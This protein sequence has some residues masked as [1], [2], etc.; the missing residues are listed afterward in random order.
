MVQKMDL[1][2][3]AEKYTNIKLTEV[4]KEFLKLCQSE[5]LN[6]LYLKKRSIYLQYPNLKKF[7]KC[8]ILK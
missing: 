1:V 3:F 8:M 7:P 2:E 4:D 6:L 5:D